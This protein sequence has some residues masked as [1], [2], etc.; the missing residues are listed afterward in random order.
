MSD[1]SILP[2]NVKGNAILSAGAHVDPGVEVE[3]TTVHANRAADRGYCV[4]SCSILSVFV[5]VDK[6][7]GY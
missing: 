6:S 3:T 7:I 5:V 1:S 2:T 4:S